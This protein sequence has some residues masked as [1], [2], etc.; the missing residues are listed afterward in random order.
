MSGVPAGRGA[1][2]KW[3]REPK[4]GPARL[5]MRD[6][7]LLPESGTFLALGHLHGRRY[8]DW[9]LPDGTVTRFWAK[10]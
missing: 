6:G 2:G 8:E 5:L 7:V 9:R 1:S 10:A 4:A 3:V